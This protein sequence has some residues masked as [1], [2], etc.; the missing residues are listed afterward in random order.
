LAP[1]DTI[2]AVHIKTRRWWSNYLHP[3]FWPTW[4]MFFLL[5][6]VT[7]L[8]FSLQ[9]HSGRLIGRIAYRTARRRRHIAEINIGLCFP[10]LDAWARVWWKPRCAG[11]AGKSNCATD[12]C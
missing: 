5:W 9:M 12:T 3:R 6:L 1:F 10:R 4:L 11:G 8:P 2:A 7:R